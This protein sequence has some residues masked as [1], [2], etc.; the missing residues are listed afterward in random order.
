MTCQAAVPRPDPGSG[1]AGGV[2]EGGA[3]PALHRPV[4]QGGGGHTP[5]AGHPPRHGGGA[6]GEGQDSG[7]GVPQ[8]RGGDPGTELF[9]LVPQID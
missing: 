4:P 8:P 1:A 9:S 2:Q 7:H 5:G 6:A 3:P